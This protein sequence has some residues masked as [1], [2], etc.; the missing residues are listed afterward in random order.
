MGLVYPNV[1]RRSQPAI[2]E[3]IFHVEKVASLTIIVQKTVLNGF[4]S[5][6]PDVVNLKIR[7]KKKQ[8][9]S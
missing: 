6:P 2:C 3:N 1:H 5:E 8:A 4:L 9:M 7:K